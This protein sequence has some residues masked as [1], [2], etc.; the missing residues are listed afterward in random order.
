MVWT[1]AAFA[2]IY[3]ATLV[4]AAAAVALAAAAA[5]PRLHRGAGR[6]LDA[7]LLLALTIVCI[8]LIPLP[9]SLRAA[10]SPHA[11]TVEAALTVGG[12]DVGARPIS[13]DPGST[14]GALWLG[15]LL[16]AMF[17][18]ARAVCDAGEVR[19]PVRAIAWS[20]LVV[21][22][23]AVVLRTRL[24]GGLLSL[25]AP[26]DYRMYGPFLNR[27]HMGTWLIM[28]LPLVVGYMFARVSDRARRTSAASALDATMVWL[29]ASAIA[30]LIATVAS[31]SRSSVVG[32]AAAGAVFLAAGPARRSGRARLAAFLIAGLAAAIVLTN[33][34]VTRLMAR[35]E[36]SRVTAAWSRSEI[37]RQT[38]PIV[39][40][41]PIAGVGA[42]AYRRAMLVYQQS[43]RALFFNQAHNQFLQVAAE[44]GVALSGALL[45]AFAALVWR[46]SAV[47][48]RDRTP[49]YWIRVGAAAGI[50]GVMV[51]SVWETGLR[52]PANGL[53]FALLCAIATC[54]EAPSARPGKPAVDAGDDR[55]RAA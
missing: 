3:P 29:A 27:N 7:A 13:L 30:M 54:R 11:W 18:C 49:M 45:L 37:W 17:W 16:V 26:G 51:Q 32:A 44:G 10:L 33:S 52:M 42:G 8:Q 22:V 31:L 28:S 25:V 5:R 23:A 6:V 43:D 38:M 1:L 34:Q 2:G 41:F 14:W 47:L 20:G 4:P 12:A 24:P 39:R 36:D 55:R 53:L 48:R 15:G 46:I 21:S 40:D 35:F 50:G 19:Q 9:P